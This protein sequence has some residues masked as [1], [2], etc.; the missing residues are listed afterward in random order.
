MTSHEPEVSKGESGDWQYQLRLQIAD[1]FTESVRGGSDT[2]DLEPLYEILTSHDA[3]V[4]CQYDAFADFCVRCESNGEIDL[5]LYKWT[6]ETIQNPAKKAKYVKVFTVYISG[7]EVYERPIA[8]AL[9]HD[10]QPLVSG[11]VVEKLTKYDSNPANNPQ[12]PQKYLNP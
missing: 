3:T 8:E 11:P 10:L 1:E 4:V 5:P 6:L 7:D 12:V 2:K 9:E